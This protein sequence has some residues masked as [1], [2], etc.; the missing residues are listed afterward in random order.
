M[1]TLKKR[2]KKK[3]K[4][5]AKQTASEFVG[6]VQ[7]QLNKHAIGLGIGQT[8]LLGDLQSNG[9]DRITADILYSYTASYS[10]DLLVNAHFSNH[11]Y[12]GRKVWLRGLTMSIK[13]RSYEYDAFSPYLLGGLGFYQPQYNNGTRT[14]EA[15]QTFGLNGGAGVD[16]RLNEDFVI[17]A[18]GQY[19]HPFEVKQD[20]MSNLRGSY[21]KLLL[22]VMYL[23]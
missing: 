22:T 4:K 15:K 8:F 9:D 23:L 17:G 11:E 10:F 7:R 13:G 1:F 21:F 19:H 14:S 5:A 12:K 2:W 20:D 3:A 6:A 16:L 18:M